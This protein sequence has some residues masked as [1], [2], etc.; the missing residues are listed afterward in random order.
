LTVNHGLLLSKLKYYGTQ[1]EILDWFKSCL[2]NRNLQVELKSSK[3]QNFCSN[4]EIVK[5][6]VP[7]GL[8][9]HLLLFDMYSND[10]P[11]QSNSLVEMILFADDTSI[12]VS[13]TNYDDFMKVFNLVICK[14]FQANQVA[15]NVEKTSI[16]RFTPIKF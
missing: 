16:V 12:L 9:M 10:F 11:L 4:W 5:H 13:H 7:K 2:Y 1:G 14:W 3:T 6:G 15:L 8:V